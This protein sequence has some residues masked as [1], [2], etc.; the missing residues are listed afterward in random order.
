MDRSALVRMYAV[1]EQRPE[2]LRK[3]V[4]AFG[5]ID[6]ALA[7]SPQAWLARGCPASI[8]QCH[9]DWP[10]GTASAA[11]AAW[12]L[13]LAWLAQPGRGLWHEFDA[14]D[15][16][17]A[18][19]QQP[20][21][22]ALHAPLLFWEG[23]EALMVLPQVAVVG[24]RAATRYG[25]EQATRLAGDLARAGLVITSGLASG[26]DGAAHE[27][28]LSA[29]GRTVAV[30]GCGPDRCYPPAHADLSRRLVAAGGLLLSEFLP[31]TTPEPWRFPRRNR[32]LAALCLGVLVVEASPRSGSL[33][34]A[35]LAD[36]LSRPIWVVPGPVNR[37]QSR[38]CHQLL[39]AGKATLVEDATD[40]MP[41][42]LEQISEWH[43]PDLVPGA[44]AVA[45]LRV[46][47]G[48]RA[49]SL[50]ALLD[51]EPQSLDRL[52]A[53]SGEP[54]GD[55]LAA[56]GE[57]EVLGWAVAVPEGYQRLSA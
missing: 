25:L 48:V 3:L 29:G 6:A 16:P 55:V 46:E 33:I 43:G 10:A 35:G 40:V 15:L 44:P 39:K 2:L 17:E 56:L 12:T 42:V 54:P 23:D 57:L 30:L 53:R 22:G 28:A 18:F 20:E 49:A 36:S 52:V 24:S 34:T 8:A 4:Q 37:A 9:G 13:T 41:G 51:D 50:R 21:D 45:V 26:I 1:V 32:T 27:A 47:P 31:G 14:D 7:A 38:G 5:G 19:R 11:H